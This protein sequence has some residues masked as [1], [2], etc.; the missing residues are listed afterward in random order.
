MK[1]RITENI[2]LK[3]QPEEISTRTHVDEFVHSG[4]KPIL[5]PRLVQV[6]FVSQCGDNHSDGH[7]THLENRIRAIGI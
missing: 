1:F 4:S 2:T 7:L 6:F 3:S 5:I